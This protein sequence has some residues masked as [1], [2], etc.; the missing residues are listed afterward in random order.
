MNFE[1]TMLT[2]YEAAAR[3]IDREEEEVYQ[4]LDFN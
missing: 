2:L 1:E 3:Y 4:E